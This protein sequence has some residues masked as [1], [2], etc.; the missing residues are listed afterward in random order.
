MLLSQEMGRG[1]M[2]VYILIAATLLVACSV[3]SDISHYALEK[4]VECR[5]RIPDDVAKTMVWKPCDYEQIVG[6]IPGGV[7]N[8]GF[9][10][11]ATSFVYRAPPAPNMATT[12]VTKVDLEARSFVAGQRT[13]TLTEDEIASLVDVLNDLWHPPPDPPGSTCVRSVTHRTENL[14]LFDGR[15]VA[16]TS[17]YGVGCALANAAKSIEHTM[18]I[19]SQR[20]K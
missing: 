15:M 2:R 7:P 20:A 11:T 17:L 19:V 10:R 16:R 4:S 8:K 1:L 12:E 9:V 3:K 18:K 14:Y 13:A 6:S 5:D